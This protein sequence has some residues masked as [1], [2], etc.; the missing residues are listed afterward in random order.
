MSGWEVDHYGLIVVV[1][2]ADGT[3]ETEIPPTYLSTLYIFLFIYLPLIYLL[4]YTQ[5]HTEALSKSP[6]L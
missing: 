6:P 3:N 1:V 5:T 2:V 4:S